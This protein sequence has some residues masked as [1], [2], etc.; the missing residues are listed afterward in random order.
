MVRIGAQSKCAGEKCVA[1]VKLTRS[2]GPLSRGDEPT[3][4]GGVVRVGAQSKG[5]HDRL[6]ASALSTRAG[7]P[8]GGE[9]QVRDVA[10]IAE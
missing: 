7:R 4:R 5:L 1:T 3:G 6:G 2:D 8:Q 9:N 10:T